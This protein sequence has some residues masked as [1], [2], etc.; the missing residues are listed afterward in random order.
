[1]KF[2][3]NLQLAIAQSDNATFSQEE[4][5]HL[6]NIVND[7]VKEIVSKAQNLSLITACVSEIEMVG[8]GVMDDS[9]NKTSSFKQLDSTSQK[10]T[11]PAINKNLAQYMSMID[12]LSQTPWFVKMFGSAFSTNWKK[13]KLESNSSL[14]VS[15]TQQLQKDIQTAKLRDNLIKIETLQLR[16]TYKQM[17][18]YLYV[19]KLLEEETTKLNNTDP[20]TYRDITYVTHQRANAIQEFV[21]VIDMQI[22][23]QAVVAK[24]SAILLETMQKA[25]TTTSNVAITNNTLQQNQPVVG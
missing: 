1:M 21:T 19:I 23:S 3:S 13:R 24:N 2:L 17:V 5:T 22:Q 15:K 20:T 6:A 9:V 4:K 14:I 8:R 12:K 11:L 18:R 25:I 10:Y 7:F 16:D